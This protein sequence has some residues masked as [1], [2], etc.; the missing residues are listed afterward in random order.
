MGL[1]RDF[2]FQAFHRLIPDNW[3]SPCT[4]VERRWFVRIRSSRFLPRDV[5]DSS[6]V[7]WSGSV[8]NEPLDRQ[9]VEEREERRRPLERYVVF[10]FP[11]IAHGYGG[12]TRWIKTGLAIRRGPFR[13]RTGIEWRSNGGSSAR[14]LPEIPF[15]SGGKSGTGRKNY[16]WPTGFISSLLFFVKARRR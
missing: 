16:P 1:H 13:D 3:K 15:V 8:G 4:N 7:K 14:L 5:I 11:G 12:I 10:V 2:A 6:T 9:G